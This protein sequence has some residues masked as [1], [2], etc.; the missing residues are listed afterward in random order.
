MTQ[1]ESAERADRTELTPLH[2]RLHEVFNGCSY[3]AI[4]EQTQT[5]PE[6][7]RRYMQ[8]QAPSVEFLA[9]VCHVAGVNGQWMLTGR[10]PK[11]AEHIRAHA[12]DEANASELLTAMAR[13]LERLID[14]VDRLEL[15]VQTMETRLR[16]ATSLDHKGGGGEPSTHGQGASSSSSNVAGPGG[17]SSAAAIPGTAV[18]RA[19]WIAGAI[20]REG[21]TQRPIDRATIQRPRSLDH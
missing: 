15:Y 7:V 4:G 8:G 3:R 14:R 17:K 12:L 9:Q 2:D 13:T 18:E 6:T 21:T 5:S 20:V 11:K 19:D 16:V 1:S 10:G